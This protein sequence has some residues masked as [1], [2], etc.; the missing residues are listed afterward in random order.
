[1]FDAESRLDFLR[2]GDKYIRKYAAD[3]TWV[4]AVVRMQKIDKKLFIKLE[5]VPNGKGPF[6][7]ENKKL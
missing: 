6:G 1:L 4:V 5:I 2:E 7:K 3:V